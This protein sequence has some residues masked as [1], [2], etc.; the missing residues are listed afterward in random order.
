LALLTLL[1]V[2]SAIGILLS[3]VN[4]YLRDTQHFVELALLAWFWVTPIVYPFEMV[5]SRDTLWSKIWMAN[6][7][8]PIVITFQRALYAK[9]ENTSV[10]PAQ[11]LLP[12]WDYWQY[13]AYLGMSLAF[14]LVM[15][16]IAVYVFGR[17]ETNFA[18]EL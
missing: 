12:H 10:S 6:P 2:T 16:V 7:I 11:P 17:S 1:L 5:A 8:T 3:A 4:V 13:M 14:G 18:E 15:L 9:L